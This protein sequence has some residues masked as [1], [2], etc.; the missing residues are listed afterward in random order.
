MRPLSNLLLY[1]LF[2][3]TMT[4]RLKCE[5]NSSKWLMHWLPSK[6]SSYLDSPTLRQL[7]VG[8]IFHFLNMKFPT[9][10]LILVTKLNREVESNQVN[11]KQLELRVQLGGRMLKWI[12]N[13]EFFDMLPI[14]LKSFQKVINLIIFIMPS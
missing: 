3:S 5:W 1:F 6:T 7:Q 14:L 9:K 4:Y 13:M 12:D 10:I 11:E 8:H 2:R